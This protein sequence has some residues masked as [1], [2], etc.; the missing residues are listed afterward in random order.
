L[1]RQRRNYAVALR[2]RLAHENAA[3]RRNHANARTR[4]NN[5]GTRPRRSHHGARPGAHNAT[6]T[7]D[8]PGGLGFGRVETGRH[9]NSRGSN[10]CKE[11]RTHS[12]LS[13]GL[14]RHR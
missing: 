4:R 6:R 7:T 1:V 12:G 9:G 8:A 10:R 5:N 11:Q 2:E 14:I 13:V 3:A